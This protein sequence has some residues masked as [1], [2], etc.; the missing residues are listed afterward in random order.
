MAY[1][2][3]TTA[4]VARDLERQLAGSYIDKIVG[5]SA[6]TVGLLFWTGGQNHWALFSVHPQHARVVPTANRLSGG[7]AEP[8]SFVMLL[9]KHLE[10]QRV[11]AIAQVGWIACSPSRLD[12][13]A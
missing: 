11:N 10:G 13:P 8:S 6:Q 9:R 5:P 12:R 1:D 2:F 3:V 7:G 4:A